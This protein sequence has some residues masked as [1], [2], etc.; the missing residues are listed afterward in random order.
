MVSY[1]Q[2]YIWQR[3]SVHRCRAVRVHGGSDV[4][5]LIVLLNLDFLK[6]FS[7]YLVWYQKL[8]FGPQVDKLLFLMAGCG[9]AAVI[10]KP[11]Q[12]GLW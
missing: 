5:E 2:K 11:K 3:L 12:V 8:E 1:S 10:R 9:I 4:Q 6:A 7:K